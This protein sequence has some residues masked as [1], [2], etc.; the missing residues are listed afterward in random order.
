MAIESAL[1][2]QLLSHGDFD[3]WNNL[4][5]HYFPEGDYR[6]LW[7]IVD[8]HV[9]KFHNLPSFEDLRYEI[10]NRELLEKIHA[11]E[12]VDTDVPAHELLEYL[13]D[14][15]AQAEILNRIEYFLENKITIAD[16]KENIDYLQELVVNLEDKV[17]IST[18]SESMETI[19]LFDDIEDLHK[20][21]PLGLNSDY[22]MR[23]SF[24]PKD[25][26][27]VGASS[28]QG[29]SFTCCNIAANARK[30]GKTVLYFTI[31]MESRAIIQRIAAISSSVSL[32]RLRAG[33]L[34]IKEWKA[35]AQWWADRF[36]GGQE[37][38]DKYSWIT[39]AESLPEFKKFHN[40]LRRRKFLKEKQLEVHYDPGLTMAKIASVVRQK[41]V[42]YE[43][44]G[45]I[46][47][48]YLN[49]VRRH[50]APS[51]SGQ[52]EWTEQIEISKGLK[53]LAQENN[54]LVISAFQTDTKG[55][56]R[57][58][59]GI[60]DAVDAA[61]VL[62]QWGKE[63]PAI[64]FTNKKMRSGEQESFIS[65]LDWDSWKIGPESAH[66]PDEQKGGPSEEVEDPF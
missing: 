32:N 14:Q 64:K 25:L 38:L 7:T 51:R 22:D 35:V 46:V 45:L 13:K 9:Q 30:A 50:N 5:L 44:L 41:R 12:T 6:K 65:E 26:V 23:H 49:Q 59:K 34:N 24:S 39:G 2:K 63:V 8:K 52:Y 11:I 27:V 1:L 53:S 62:Q 4:R 54:C 18:E 33:N 48:D 43:D 28:G 16:A 61:Y 29:K 58:A 56:A 66:D 57:F 21:L 20:Y 55:E 3:T 42:E 19:E 37:I 40:E 31:E 10:R 47:V 60:L 36:E 17:D 15:F